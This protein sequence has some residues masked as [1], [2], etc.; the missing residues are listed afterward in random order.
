MALESQGIWRGVYGAADDAWND[1]TAT[2]ADVPTSTTATLVKPAR[3]K[4]E[5]EVNVDTNKDK[6]VSGIDPDHSPFLE[7]PTALVLE[8][9]THLDARVLCIISCACTLF[10]RL[11]SDSHGW[12]DFYCERWGL[13][14]ASSPGALT[15]SA[16]TW[17]ELYMER[18]ERSK[19][20]MGRFRMD[21][22]HGHTAAV[23]CIRLLPAANLIFTAGYD[24]VVRLWN[25][26]EGLPLTCS[27]PLGETVRALAVD[28][29]LL[30]AAGSD[31]IIRVW[32]AIPE[33][34]HRFDVAGGYGS[35]SSKGVEVP[36]YGHTG[37]ITCI[38]LDTV[39]IYSGSWD[40]SVRVWERTSLKFVRKLMHMDWVWALVPRGRRILSTAG[41]DVYAWD[42]ESGQMVRMRSGVHVGQ[43]YAVDGSRSGHFVFTGGEDGVVRMFDDRI[44]RRRNAESKIAAEA[45][46]VWTPHKGAV[47]S[48]VFEDPWLVSASGDGALAMMDVRQI[49]KKASGTVKNFASTSTRWRTSPQFVGKEGEETTQRFLPGFH[50]SAYSVDLGADRIVSGGE[51]KIVRIWD[52]SQALEI[53]RRVQASRSNHRSR[54]KLPSLEQKGKSERRNGSSSRDKDHVESPKWVSLGRTRKGQTVGGSQLCLG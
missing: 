8:I 42:V 41:S 11:A 38:G 2:N 46:A 18:E 48:L 5:K 29:D 14:A 7:L 50:Q 51:E 44:A 22:L 24:Q 16:K 10:R 20:L 35:T 36:L 27:R 23:R 30:A 15:V 6:E 52:F 19:V 49:M 17:R 45:I 26:E 12:K 37:P 43:A 47:Y 31:A 25:L 28:M 32:Q 9:F 54:R 53:E 21:M 33:C 40:M 34:P 13:P 39:N 3:V 4:H 1:S